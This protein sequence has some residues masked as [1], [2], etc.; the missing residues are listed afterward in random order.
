MSATGFELRSVSVNYSGHLA[1]NGMSAALRKG[2]HTAV[3][4]QRPGRCC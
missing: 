4:H 2:R 1:L 3:L